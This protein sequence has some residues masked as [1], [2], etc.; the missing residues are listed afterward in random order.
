MA[1][2]AKWSILTYIAA[3]NNLELLG[4]VSRQQ[5]LGVGSTA[6]VVHGM[7]YDGSVGAARY[8]IGNAGAVR[9]QERLGGFNSG[10]PD[11][12]IETAKWFYGENPADRYGLVLWS[13]GTGW[14][15]SEIA[16][17][18]QETRLAAERNDAE[19]AERAGS[20]G[21]LTLFRSTLRQILTPEHERERA[22][23]FDDGSGQSLDTLEL[24][25]VS[26][27]I[28][29]AI[30][31]PLEFLGMDA[32]LMANLEVAYQLRHV[33]RY[34]VASPELVP[35]HSWPYPEI[36][37]NLKEDPDQDGATLARTTVNH[38]VAFYSANPPGRGD[39]TKVALDLGRIDSLKGAA[40]G[41]ARSLLED[42]GRNS[43]PLWTAQEST[44]KLESRKGARTPS[45][46]EFHLW[47]L[48]AVAAALQQ[49]SDV[50]DS[51]NSAARDALAALQPS[52]G[53]VLAEG[54]QGAWFDGT[55]GVSIYLPVVA[56][57]S[58]WYP[59]LAFAS[60]TQWDEMLVAY[61]QQ[62]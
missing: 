32:C 41:L 25:R 51:V 62:F 13:H 17:V 5:I 50:A 38:Y 55:R 42:I 15:P 54:H 6:D 59:A 14:M 47:D 8:I 24:E 11:A 36:Y 2:D 52:A 18:A 40:D 3:H 37:G 21:S 53:A 30:G 7:L 10:D 39:V 33:V 20:S 27:T 46:F 48:G 4:K 22:I 43:G 31:K 57:I 61:H 23:L 12:L 44:Q 49:S 1:G 29:E 19:A 58:P 34:M 16:Q 60:D 35:G 28:A 45:K 9:T 56:R 26:R